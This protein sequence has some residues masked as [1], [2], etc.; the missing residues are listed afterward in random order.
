V[1]SSF[2]IAAPAATV[3]TAVHARAPA[4]TAPTSLQAPPTRAALV[5]NL[6]AGFRHVD[7]NGDGVLSKDELGISQAKALQDRLAA[8]RRRMGAAFDEL[9]TNH[10]GTLRKAEFIAAAPKAPGAAPDG[11]ALP[12]LDRTRIR[13]SR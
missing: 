6:N 11:A 3:T 10:D 9:D 8:A 12:Q 7:T 1:V 4:A 2:A 13:G 5:R